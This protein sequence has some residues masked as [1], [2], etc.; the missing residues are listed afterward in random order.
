MNYS[1]CPVLS[2]EK[3]SDVVYPLRMMD[4]LSYVGIP[5]CRVSS[6]TQ[7]ERLCLLDQERNIIEAMERFGQTATKSFCRTIKGDDLSWL[8]EPVKYAK[9]IGNGAIVFDDMTRSIRP[10]EF[11]RGNRNASL[12]PQE[13][14]KLDKILKGFPAFSVLHPD[15]NSSEIRS[16]QTKRGQRQKG[17]TG[18]N[19][20]K[21][22]KAFRH[23]WIEEVRMMRNKEMTLREIATEIERR[24]GV[25]I[26][27][28]SIM[29][30]T[31]SLT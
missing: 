12:T 13:L 1:H 9:E 31:T 7:A 23:K 24:S 14:E 5:C 30:W 22:R 28:V 18:G 27:H 2:Y 11:Y 3:A 8:E 20:C 16:H 17:K 4:A 26:S 10:A 21:T 19:H 15:A 25:Y 6:E 29:N